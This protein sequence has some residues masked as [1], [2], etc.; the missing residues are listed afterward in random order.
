[1]QLKQQ[2]LDA[3]LNSGG[4][5]SPISSFRPVGS[6]TAQEL[7]LFAWFDR[8]PPEVR[9]AGR[10]PATQTTALLYAPLTYHLSESGTVSVPV[11][12][13]RSRV[14]SMPVQGGPC[15]P[16]GIP[17]VYIGQGEATFEFE[18]PASAR[19]LQI[20]GLTVSLRS[21]GGWQQPPEMAVYQWLDQAW[22]DLDKPVVGDNVLT[23]IQGLV[24]E[25]GR[26]RVRLSSNNGGGGCYYVGLGFEGKG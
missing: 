23:D 26:V 6:T 5:Y 22:S 1:V 15:G 20:E 8:A 3:V 13:V 9:V 11:G 17:A 16:S 12:F 7:A 19:R 10:Q 14:L 21:E 25:D 2:V 18:L 24:S 4:G